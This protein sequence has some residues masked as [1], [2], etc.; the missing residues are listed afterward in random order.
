[1]DKDNSD[2]KLNETIKRTLR[3]YEAPYNAVDWE[4][5][6]SMLDVAPK[7]SPLG[8]SY[9]PIIIFAVV[10][11]G[12][13]FLLYTVFKTSDTPEKTNTTN[14][15]PVVKEKNRAEPK[16]VETHS[17]APAP[18][19]PPVKKEIPPP[20]KTVSSPSVAVTP[21]VSPIKKEAKIT[22][23]K[24]VEKKVVEK[25]VVEKKLTEK[26]TVE[27]KTNVDK[28]IIPAAV[29][30]TKDSKKST[31]SS[32]EMKAK[33]FKKT[34]DKNKKVTKQEQKPEAKQAESDTVHIE[35]ENDSNRTRKALNTNTSGNATDSLKNSQEKKTGTKTSKK[36]TKKSKKG[37]KTSG[38]DSLEKNTERNQKDSLKTGN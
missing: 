26:K 13:A 17:V 27:K 20:V 28:T 2:I 12:A 4:Q 3:N 36:E 14:T 34:L 23:K 35:D 29:S 15:P 1:M 38:N 31:L 6:E 10:I 24:V 25:K 21:V 19:L 16:P 18:V 7:H 11:L 37:K 30:P 8:R 32:Q 33:L 22:E 5:M 9:S